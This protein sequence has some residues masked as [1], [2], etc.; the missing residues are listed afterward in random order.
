MTRE[1]T[2]NDYLLALL[3]LDT[4][5]RSAITDD[6]TLV[7]IDFDSFGNRYTTDSVGNAL[8]GN[9]SSD[10]LLSRPNEN[11]P[12]SVGFSATSYT[13]NGQKIR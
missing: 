5:S 12:S 4:Y 3:S 13:L 6:S 10:A 2:T 1:V 7:A 8:I 11:T 9:I